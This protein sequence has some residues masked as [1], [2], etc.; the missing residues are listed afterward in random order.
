MYTGF[1]DNTFYQHVTSL[2]GSEVEP[3]RIL[4][5]VLRVWD[6]ES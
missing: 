2:F 6:A 5:L 1:N 4:A 3:L